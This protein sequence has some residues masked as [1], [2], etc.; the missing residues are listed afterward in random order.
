MKTKF[1]TI[2]LGLFVS[3]LALSAGED[4]PLLYKVM[5]DQLEFRD[6]DGEDPIVWEVEAWVGKDLNKL[7]FKTEGERA[8]GR[9]E[10]IELQA[11][12]SRAIAP[13]WDLQVGW[14]HDNVPSPNRDWAVFGVQGLAPYFFEIDAALFVGSSGRS[15]IRLSAE[16]ELMLTQRLVLS[17]EIELNLFGKN[18]PALGVGS[19]LSDSELGVRLR[20][21]IRRE[22]APYVGINW[23]KQHGDTADYSRADGESTEDT[24]IVF[25]IRAWF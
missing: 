11:L 18:D 21:E 5:I 24:R 12:Y 1:L 15:S 23:S 9:S 16:Y 20:Y 4:D 3:P 25:G 2:M 14:R 13:Y 17:P 10:E 22:F 8:D 7:W 19:G 6:G